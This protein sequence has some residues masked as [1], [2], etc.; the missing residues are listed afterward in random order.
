MACHLMHVFFCGIFRRK[1]MGFKEEMKKEMGNMMH[2][3]NVG[4]SKEWQI[5]HAGYSIL[6]KNE[7]KKEELW[8]EGE[9]VDEYEHTSMWSYLRPI[10]KLKG[11]LP[12][13]E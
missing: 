12:N 2:D 3:F 10:S 13:G 4:V 5:E 8:I 6:L 11:V 1:I 7:L 9:L